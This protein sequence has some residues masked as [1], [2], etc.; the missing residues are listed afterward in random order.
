MVRKAPSRNGQSAIAGPSTLLPKHEPFRGVAPCPFISLQ[1][2]DFGDHFGDSQDAHEHA[3][4]RKETQRGSQI[5]FLRQH[6][7]PARNSY[8]TQNPVPFGECG[9][10]FH[11]RHIAE[12][13][14]NT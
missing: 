13:L 1:G 14:Q 7:A 6:R 11:L 9:F 3:I 5:R 12:P 10:K 8:R 2:D 4:S